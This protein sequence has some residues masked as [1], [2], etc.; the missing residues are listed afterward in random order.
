LDFFEDINKRQREAK[1]R[2]WSRVLLCL[3][4]LFFVTAILTYCR[5]GT[6]EEPM[7]VPAE[8]VAVLVP[9]DRV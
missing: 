1:A 8:P 9:G 6:N 4:A 3:A 7:P 5:T 2:F